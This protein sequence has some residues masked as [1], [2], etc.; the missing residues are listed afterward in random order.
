MALA[1]Q[2]RQV[3]E[4]SSPAPPV[5][6]GT[7]P[8]R[9]LLAPLGMFAAFALAAGLVARGREELPGNFKLFFTTQF[10]LM[11]WLSMAAVLLACAQIFTAAWIFRKLPWPRPDW[12]P[13][14]HRWTGRLALVA[15][16]PVVYWCIFQ[17]GF[18]TYDTRYVAHSVLGTLFVGFV[19]A[20]V[21]I[22]RLHRFPVWVYPL[23]GLL[24]FAT[25][26]GSWWTSALWFVR[27]VG[28]PLF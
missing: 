14:V 18:Q 16:A 15:V 13:A 26:I 12:I 21:T 27:V 1:F 6:R 17:L 25:L 3:S 28:N 19:A 24:V 20:K 10:H 8:P 4:I 11:T 22:I 23:A 7:R 5:A 9:W 2:S